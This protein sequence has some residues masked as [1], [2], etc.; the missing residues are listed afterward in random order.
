MT[1]TLKIEVESEMLR[2]AEEAAEAQRTTVP[3]WVTHQL[4]MMA[5]NWEDS[6]AGRTPL[7][8]A[9]R[10]AMSLPAGFKTRP[11]LEAELE[12]RHGVQR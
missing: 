4:K 12:A 3:E 7:T 11:F 2:L 5:S 6:R 10:G 8:D 1:A 9:L